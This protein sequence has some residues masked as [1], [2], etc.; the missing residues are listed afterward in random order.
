MKR[1]ASLLLM[2]GTLTFAQQMPKP[3]APP[4]YHTYPQIRKEAWKPEQHS[5]PV[6]NNGW[7]Q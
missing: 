7:V 6:V 5:G 4:E 2:G 1:F 3:A